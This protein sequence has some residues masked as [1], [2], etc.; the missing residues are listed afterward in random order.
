MMLAESKPMRRVIFHADDFGMNDAV[1]S[2]IVQSL[3]NGLLTSTSLLTNAPSADEACQRWRRVIEE[4][5]A[6][7]LQSVA[8]R[9]SLDEPRLP[10]DL[11]IHLNLTQGRPLTGDRY[12]AQLLD[13]HG[14]F[15]GVGKLFLRL[16]RADSRLLELVKEEL[17][18]QIEWMHVRGLPP[19][20]LNGHQYIELIPQIS[21]MIPDLLRRH[22]IKIVRVAREPNLFRNVLGEGRPL[23]WGLGLVKRH[24]AG[25]FVQLLRPQ[26]VAYPDCFYGTSHAGRINFETLDRFLQQ[27]PAT[28]YTEVGLHP[29]VKPDSAV[30]QTNDPWF[31]PLISNR[32]IETEWLCSDE[33]KQLL[34]R[35]QFALGR[36]QSIAVN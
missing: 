34:Q 11:G 12:P 22:G 13:S 10:F 36:L 1:N 18:S 30:Q 5:Q 19:T 21:A 17:E 2:G 20:H 24:F 7:A 25:S 28:G 26:N 23:A 14:C 6:E 4:F 3:R 29:S 35:R 9:R 31:D 8:A 32:A 16:R 15:P 27:S 33:L